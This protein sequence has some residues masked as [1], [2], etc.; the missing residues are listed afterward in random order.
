MQV[1]QLHLFMT[2]HTNLTGCFKPKA[3]NFNKI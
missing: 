3:V 1:K 2:D